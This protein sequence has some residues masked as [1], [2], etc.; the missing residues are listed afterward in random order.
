MYIHPFL[1]PLLLAGI[2]IATPALAQQ[3]AL[4]DPTIKHAPKDGVV[5]LYGAGGPHT[6]FQKVANVWQARTGETVKIVAGPEATWSKD[7]QAPASG[8]S[9][10]RSCGPDK[11]SRRAIAGV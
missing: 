7:A 11:P 10:Q 3:A 9:R 5:T 4:Y 1:H 6:A 2:L 8:Q